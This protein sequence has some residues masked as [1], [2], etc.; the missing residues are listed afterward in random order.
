MIITIL[1]SSVL[2]L[3]LNQRALK[4]SIKII[5][6][7]GT[8]KDKIYLSILL[9]N[10]LV[11]VYLLMIIINSTIFNYFLLYLC[12]IVIQ[13]I[14]FFIVSK[15]NIHNLL[16]LGINMLILFISN[17]MYYYQIYNNVI[18][19]Y[20]ITLL[21]FQ[22]IILFSLNIYLILQLKNKII[23]LNGRKNVK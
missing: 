8:K 20:S 9:V 15:N 21:L 18:F 7:L 5:I 2:I 6:K 13:T 19:G 10:F 14:I 16:F 11:Y 4:K 12:I 22:L 1:I 3:I 23:I 17:K